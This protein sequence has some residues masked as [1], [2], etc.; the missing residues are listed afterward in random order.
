VKASKFLT[1]RSTVI[2]LFTAISAALLLASLVPQ[3]ASLGGKAPE[4]V[5]RLPEGLLFLSSRL[6]ADNVVGSAWFSALVALFW[7]SLL[8]STISQFG[9]TRAR[10][11]RVPSAEVP[12]GSIRI[13]LPPARLAEL[14]R[15]AG[16]RPAGS[17]AGVQRYVKNLAGYW[18]NFL[19]H[20]GLV[21]AVVFSLIY[22]LTQHRVLIRLV[23]EETSRFTTSNVQ[24][25]R[26]VLPLSYRL[27]YTALLKNL[28]PRFYG[29]DRLEYLASE[30][31]FTER[32][33]GEPARVAVALSDKAQFG[34]Y[35]VYQ[36]N[37]FGRAFD[38]ELQLPGETHR[39]RLYLPYPNR[40]DAAGYGEVPITGT[41]YL[42]KAKFYSDLNRKSM[43]LNQ[44][45]LTL[46]LYRGK[47]LLHELTLA[48]GAS[49][50]L[51]PFEVR[52]AQAQWWTDILLDGSRGTAGIFAGFAVIL[53]GVLSSYCLVPREIIVRNRDGALQVQQVARRFPEFYREEFNDLIRAANQQA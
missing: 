7:L 45:P 52:L 49:G 26:G 36:A 11:R 9:A 3:R 37:A 5:G 24:E 19:L 15:G 8:M 39:E 33:G 10:V 32:P 42:L 47:E 25:M 12:Q 4:W 35:L 30:L 53:A 20:I 34:D 43:Q 38:L 17:A 46:R 29:N 51:G 13:S 2:A 31:Y 14:L 50:V 41:E 27:P 28:Q 18:G 16:Y 48:P 21:T 23:G 6:G 40:R 22:V 1:A 44:P